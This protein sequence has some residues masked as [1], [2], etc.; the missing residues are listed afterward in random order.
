MA[1]CGIA[2]QILDALPA[3]VQMRIMRA[4]P[5]LEA[6]LLSLPG[7][8]HGSAMCAKIRTID[9]AGALQVPHN[10]TDNAVWA[11]GAAA[12]GTLTH[13]TRLSAAFSV[14]GSPYNRA[15]AAQRMDHLLGSLDALPK[16]RSL[17]LCGLSASDGH[18]TRVAECVQQL[19]GLT[20]LRLSGTVPGSGS[21]RKVLQQCT[22]LRRLSL[23]RLTLSGELVGELASVLP[24][25]PALFVLDLSHSGFTHDM[26][27]PLWA[28]LPR[29]LDL[30]TLNLS[31]NQLGGRQMEE[32]AGRAAEDLGD[33]APVATPTHA[34]HALDL[35]GNSLTPAG[36]AVCDLQGALPF[37]HGQTALTRLDLTYTSALS[38]N[39]R[40]AHTDALSTLTC[41][42][43]LRVQQC[44][45]G[46]AGAKALAQT[47]PTLQALTQLDIPFNV[48]GSDGAAACAVALRELQQLQ[49]LSLAANEIGDFGAEALAEAVA[50]LP[51]LRRLSLM[52]NGIGDRGAEAVRQAIPDMRCLRQL[53]LAGNPISAKCQADVEA[54]CRR[55]GVQ[56]LAGR[57]TL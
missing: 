56:V 1:A 48:I 39:V 30:R 15:S 23:A 18:M 35:T 52:A 26:C 24:S 42:Q 57:G 27:G 28:V 6:L 16:L 38:V 14:D 7:H 51:L 12:V 49:V 17:T 37:V 31:F 9:A 50:A 21:F 45:L 46:V 19:P 53:I 20:D 47:L 54:V 2:L 22:A 34:L 41:L 55:Q 8:L 29:M 3:G 43:C 11:S 44:G 4:A 13:L 25:I 36:N 5:S 40:A 10:W 32:W 33:V